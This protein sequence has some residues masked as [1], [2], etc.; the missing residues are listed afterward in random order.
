MIGGGYQLKKNRATVPRTSEVVTKARPERARCL[1]IW[2]TPMA[3]E[4]KA[5]DGT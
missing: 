4:A 5:T 3:K 1:R 2:T